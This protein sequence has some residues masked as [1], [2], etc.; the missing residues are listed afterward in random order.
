MTRQPSPEQCARLILGAVAHL[1]DTLTPRELIALRL[2][3]RASHMEE[4]LLLGDTDR[5]LAH[6]RGVLGLL[7]ELRKLQR[8]GL[9]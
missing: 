5:A 1:R 9:V 2:G 8:I 3:L 4:A 6:F 7:G